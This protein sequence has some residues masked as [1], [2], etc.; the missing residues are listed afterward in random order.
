MRRDNPEARITVCLLYLTIP[1]LLHSLAYVGVMRGYPL[2]LFIIFFGVGQ[3]FGAANWGTLVAAGLDL[4]PPPFR[5]TA[6]SFLP[7]FQAIASLSAGV[8]SGMLSDLYGLPVTMLFL[9]IVGMVGGLLLLNVARKNYD[10][11]QQKTRA[12]GS[13]AVEVD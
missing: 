9:L 1:L 10:R 8:I 11:D 5:A 6:Q 13:F 4:S 2:Y 12:L 3:F 7:M